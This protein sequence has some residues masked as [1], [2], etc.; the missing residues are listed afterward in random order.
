MEHSQSDITA[1][2]SER[3]MRLW[4]ALHSAEHGS[5]TTGF[6]KFRYRFLTLSRDDGSL[7]DEIASALARRLGWRVYDKEIVN[8]IAE[9]HRVREDLVRQLDER[10]QGLVHEAILR[11]LR[12]PESVSFGSEEYHESLMK[13]LATLAARGSA[14]LVGRG[15]NFVLRGS[16][17]GLHIR[18]TGSLEVRL[19]R[20]SKNWNLPEGKARPCLLAIDEDRRHFI[21]RHFRKRFDDLDCYDLMFNT[22]HLTVERVVNSV[23]AAMLPELP[24]ALARAS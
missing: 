20:V 4:S 10:D 17:Q 21:R 9:N 16:E 7:G 18:V 22:D 24:E 14:V 6:E 3:Q 8:F 15:A 11:L 2:I 23:L 13:T 5:H 1:R 19:S 12:M